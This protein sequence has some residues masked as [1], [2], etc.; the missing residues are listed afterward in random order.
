MTIPSNPKYLCLL[1]GVAE[2]MLKCMNFSDTERTRT[3]LALDEAVTNIIRHSCGCD[4]DIKVDITLS[5]TDDEIQIT[6]RDFGDCGKDFNIDMVSKKDMD[7]VTPGGFGVNII[8]TVMDS[9]VYKTS[10]KDGNV[11][12]MRKKCG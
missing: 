6:V 2:S 9:V 1:R 12:I 10:H 3:I 4:P 11:L 7:N 8:K 5:C